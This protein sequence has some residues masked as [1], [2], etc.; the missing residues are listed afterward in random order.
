M[1]P[2]W[3]TLA[4]SHKPPRKQGRHSGSSIGGVLFV[5]LIEQEGVVL[6]AR[7]G[8]QRLARFPSSL[9][10]RGKGQPKARIERGTMVEAAANGSK[11]GNGKLTK[12][13]RKR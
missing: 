9:S 1:P 7:G 5:V 3:P 10:T 8:L 12:N 13:Q 11:P 6:L 4:P 2:G